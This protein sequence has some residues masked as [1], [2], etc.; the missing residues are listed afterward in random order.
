ME[1]N[2]ILIPLIAYFTAGTV[3]FAINSLKSRKWAFSNIGM[4]GMP[5]THN[6]ITSSTFFAI[7]FG[8]GFGSPVA[9]VALMVS[10]IVGLDSL[11]LRRKIE[12]HAIFI[13]K[14]LRKMNSD[15]PKIRT[16]IGHTPIEVLG[17]WLLGGLLAYLLI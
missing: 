11:D 17:G 8:E 3:K 13:S 1:F 7:G 10:V 4:G 5:S 2:Y 6:T 16:K 12:L 14:E 15:T 9:A